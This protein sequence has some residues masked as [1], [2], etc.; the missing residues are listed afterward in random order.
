MKNSVIKLFVLSLILGSVAS[1]YAQ[2]PTVEPAVTKFKAAEVAK[3]NKDLEK[4]IAL[5]KEALEL[6]PEY[7]SAHQALVSARRSL[8]VQLYDADV[9]KGI[10]PAEQPH[11]RTNRELREFYGKKIAEKPN[12]AG[13]Q[14]GLGFAIGPEN[15]ED[16]SR[17]Y[18]KAIELNPKFT[19]AY[20]SLGSLAW[21]IYDVVGN[22]DYQKKAF[23][24]VPDSTNRYYRYAIAELDVDKVR[25]RKLLRDLADKYPKDVYAILAFGAMADSYEDEANKAK[26]LEEMR[27][28]FP[29]S[30]GGSFSFRMSGLFGIYTRND[31]PK[32]F[33]LA[34]EM[35]GQ[36]PDSK[37]WI[38]SKD[39]AANV[40]EA[41]KLIAAKDFAAAAALLETTKPWN[42]TTDITEFSMLKAAA[43]N[44]NAKAYQILTTAVLKVPNPKLEEALADYGK[45]LGKSKKITSDDLWAARVAASTPLKDFDLPSF[46]LEANK[47]VTKASLKGKVVLMN[48]WFPSCGPCRPE[49][50]HFESMLK[51]YRAKGFEIMALNIVPNEDNVIDL[52]VKQSGFTFT[53]L[54]TPGANWARENYNA[55]LAPTNLL[56]DGEGRVMFRPQIRDEASAK[57]FELQIQAL[58]E[59]L[60]K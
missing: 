34:T 47:R 40:L 53:P 42:N 3:Q 36:F 22:R 1:V 23:E 59:R 35:V 49:L 24:M 28:R 5:Y 6:D 48:F 4:A 15:M 30:K 13:F 10:V 45:K 11:T 9:K 44:D 16:S 41:R 2:T 29:G 18:K 14:W 56:V 52:F 46:P 25:G 33:E 51:R 7:V 55:A 58:L 43:A 31:L 17:A 26:V 32:A 39:F 21:R 8:D 54:Q 27:K 60:K 20:D 57:L 19:E 50:P 12:S 37:E 38:A